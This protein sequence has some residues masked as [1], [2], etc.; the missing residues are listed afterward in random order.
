[1]RIIHL[2]IF[3]VRQDFIGKVHST[4]K[5]LEKVPF[6]SYANSLP[7]ISSTFIELFL[8][9]RQ[10]YIQYVWGENTIPDREELLVRS[11]RQR[12]SPL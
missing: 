10:C 6:F 3:V 1:M 2:C 5:V 7:Y 12:N 4:Q 9:A 8:C 11:G